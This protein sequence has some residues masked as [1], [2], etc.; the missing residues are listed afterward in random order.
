MSLS[1]LS[2]SKIAVKLLTH[3]HHNPPRAGICDL[4]TASLQQLVWEV[5]W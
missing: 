1:N 3:S 5:G 4:P 2:C